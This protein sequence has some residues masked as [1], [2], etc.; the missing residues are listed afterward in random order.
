ML[1]RR[2]C[3]VALVPIVTLVLFGAL[4]IVQLANTL[5]NPDFYVR[6]LRA[7]QTYTR[8]H[9]EVLPL[10]LD[11]F[12]RRQDEDLPENLRSFELPT[13]A[14]SQATMLEAARGTFPPAYVQTTTEHVLAE[15]LGYL[16]ARRD[17]F[18]LTVSL[19]EPLEALAGHPEGAPSRLE[20][21]YADLGLG[22]VIIEGA[23]LAEGGDSA[24]NRALLSRLLA[25]ADTTVSWFDGEVFASVDEV[26]PWLA[27]D[28]DSF[29][30]EVRFDE[31][32][33]LAVPLAPVLRRTPSELLAT[34]FVLEPGDV[35]R[36][37]AASD[38]AALND[39]ERTLALFRPEGWSYTDR[40]LVEDLEARAA[41]RLAS[42]A[43]GGGLDVDGVRTAAKIVRGPARWALIAGVLLLLVIVGTLGGRSWPVRAIWA[44]SAMLAACLT[45][46]AASGPFGF[47]PRLTP[48][49]HEHL[50][51]GTSEWSGARGVIRDLLD[52]TGGRFVDA[53]V[54]GIARD[55]LILG[56]L[57]AAALAGAALWAR[58]TSRAG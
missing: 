58:R 13:D 9:D 36:E 56:V 42:G 46:F 35:R 10:V 2:G 4:A 39:V 30:I 47:A 29:R 23:V 24:F 52:D 55:A 11:E 34:G 26:V 20:V 51:A 15:F 33:E 18:A 41:A 28:A 53:F 31:Y 27:G 21:A 7:Q 45:I 1:L 12:L 49:V 38:G 14:A 37:L 44:A 19:H 3:A 22:P 8:L 57:A 16:F 32:P 25:D 43:E 50:I 5:L 6:E 54:D 17:H 48:K 40:D